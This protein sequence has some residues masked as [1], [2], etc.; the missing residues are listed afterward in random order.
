MNFSTE[1]K[2]QVGAAGPFRLYFAR[3]ATPRTLHGVYYLPAKYLFFFFFSK[4]LPKNE[5]KT[6]R[7]CVLQGHP[8][9]RVPEAG[10]RDGH[11]VGGGRAVVDDRRPGLRVVPDGPDERAAGRADIHR[12]RVPAAG[13][14]GRQAHVVSAV[15]QPVGRR[16]RQVV[17]VQRDAVHRQRVHA[18][19]TGRDAVLR[20]RTKEARARRFRPSVFGSDARQD[21]RDTKIIFFLSRDNILYRTIMIFVK[22]FYNNDVFFYLAR[23]ERNV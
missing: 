19:Q 4:Y 14:D 16:Q 6:V 7:F 22:N 10:D 23:D 20:A 2:I 3:T 15:G 1:N 13:V 5:T 18:V 12:G 21:G 8:G 11:H 17:H 9:P